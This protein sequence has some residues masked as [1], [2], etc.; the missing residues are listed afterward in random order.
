MSDRIET[1]PG[2]AAGDARAEDALDALLGE[3]SQ[4]AEAPGEAL[5]ARIAAQ[6]RAM[7]PRPGAAAPSGQGAGWLRALLGGWPV[8]GGLAAA[9]AAGVMIGGAPPA[10]LTAFASDVMGQTVSYSLLSDADLYGLED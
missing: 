5:M 2:G 9:A 10:A 7:Q 6:G 8:A 4:R 3:V 1:P